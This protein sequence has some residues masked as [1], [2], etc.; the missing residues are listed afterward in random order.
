[1]MHGGYVNSMWRFKVS[2]E[3]SPALKLGFSIVTGALF[4]LFLIIT[5][6]DL[7]FQ[8]DRWKKLEDN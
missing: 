6:K 5:A 2:P 7:Q 1:M 8:L 3:T 4:F